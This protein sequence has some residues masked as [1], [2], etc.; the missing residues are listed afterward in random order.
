MSRAGS[1][2]STLDR[3]TLASVPCAG[4]TWAE[5]SRHR[6]KTRSLH[7]LPHPPHRQTDQMA[8][9]ISRC[10]AG[11][12]YWPCVYRDETK[13]VGCAGT[14]GPATR[15]K[16]IWSPAKRIVSCHRVGS[17]ALASKALRNV[18]SFGLLLSSALKHLLISR[19][20]TKMCF[21][22]GCV[23]LTTNKTGCCCCC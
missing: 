1:S 8:T 12:D 6:N 15:T 13:Q 5:Q 20:V 9:R 18:I 16:T 21:F 17:Q 22:S 19:A 2:G 4:K 3:E 11:I 7:H 23:K 10:L 14:I